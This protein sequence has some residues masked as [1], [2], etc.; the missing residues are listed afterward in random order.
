LNI[1]ASLHCRHDLFYYAAKQSWPMTKGISWAPSVVNLTVVLKGQYI[2]TSPLAH[3]SHRQD[4]NKRLR[5]SGIGVLLL[6]LLERLLENRIKV[7]A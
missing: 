4:F 3:P 7:R 1:A 6:R 2:L 5:N